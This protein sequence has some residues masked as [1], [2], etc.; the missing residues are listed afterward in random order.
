MGARNILAPVD[1]IAALCKY[2]ACLAAVPR[3]SGLSS[4]TLTDA[5][6]WPKMNGSSP[7]YWKSILR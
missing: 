4:S 6:S 3:A 7:M 2:G 1:I 5:K